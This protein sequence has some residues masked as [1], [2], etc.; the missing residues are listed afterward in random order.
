MNE[1]G[2]EIAVVQRNA[3]EVVEDDLVT[4]PDVREAEVAQGEGIE[5]TDT[6]DEDIAALRP[7]QT[8]D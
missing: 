7:R 4:R 2:V 1:T 6:G 8:V 3:G 5:I